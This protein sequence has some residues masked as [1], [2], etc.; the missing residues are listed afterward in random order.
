MPGPQT[1]RL[2]D[3][4]G[5]AYELPVEEAAD[6]LSRNV[7]F[8]VE[9]GADVADRAAANVQHEIYGGPVG[10]AVAGLAGAA[11]SV[12]GGGSD[13][14]LRA[15]GAGDKLRKLREENPIASTVGEVAGGIAPIGVSGVAARAGQRAAGVVRGGG[16][17]SDI[18]RAGIAGGVE[19][20]IQGIGQGVSEVALSDKPLELEQMISVIGTNGLMGVGVGGA[21]GGAG[22]GVE[23]GLRRAKAALDDVAGRGLG[24]LGEAEDLAKLDAKGLRA[25]HKTELEAIEAARVPQRAQLAD[26]IKAFRQELKDQKVWLATKGIDDAEIKASAIGK[27]TLKADKGLDR[28]LDDPKAL[29]ENPKTVLSHL[30]VQEAALDDMVNKHGKKLREVYAADTSGTRAAALDFAST[31]LDKNR[32]LQAKISEVSGAP[33]SARLG[34]IVDAQAALSG[35]KDGLMDTLGGAAI[36]YGLGELTGIPELGM[37]AGAARVAAP[38]IRKLGANQAAI[39]ARGSKAVGAL[40]DVTRKVAPA[41]PVLATKVLG[42]VRYAMSQDEKPKAKPAKGAKPMVLADVY[43][44]RSQELRSH[45]ETAPDGTPQ[46]RLS[47]RQKIAAQLAPIA[48]AD[49]IAADRLETIAARRLEFLASKI[50]RRPDLA[51]MQTG[52]DRWQPSDMEMRAFARYVAAVEDPMGVVERLADGSITPEDAETMR[53]VYPEMYADIQ[54]QIVEQLGELRAQLP[55]QRRLA[56]S[57][58]SGVPVDP[59]LDPRVLAVLQGT[60]ASEPGTE[61]GTMAPTASPQFGSVT[62]PSPTPAQE[63]GG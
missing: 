36:G 54:R 18:A 4:N 3:A 2:V 21:V 28:L 58:F 9:T 32:A 15:L 13:A 25:A 42:S 57:I 7:G 27:R 60:F 62:K 35:P 11:R 16:V 56:L 29:A 26:E 50:P 12:T 22:K 17:V 55:Y 51:G 24:Q 61:G 59:S 48:A 10:T 43:R 8:R 41:A 46:V 1:V 14:A 47:T 49:P 5:G 63:R 45:I 52:P 30:R 23:R 37:V 38:F 6:L 40:L 19:S 44:A 53:T 31:A 33:A 39:A 20:G 34:A